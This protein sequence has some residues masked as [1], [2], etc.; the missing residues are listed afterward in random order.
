MNLGKRINPRSQKVTIRHWLTLPVCTWLGLVFSASNAFAESRGHYSIGYQYISVDGFEATFGK[1]DIGTTDTHTLTFDVEYELTRRLTVS[2]GL[3]LVRKR[4][5]GPIPHRVDVLEPAQDAKFIDDGKYRTNFQDLH[6]GLR[7]KW[8]EGRPWSVEPFVGYSFPTNDYSFFGHAAVGQNLWHVELG[9]TITYVPHFYD[10]YVSVTPSW[11]FVEKTLGHSVHHY[12]VN[13]T[14][15]YRFTDRFSGRIFS[16]V[17]NGKGLDN[18]DFPQ[19]QIDEEWFYHDK[20]IA[21]NYINAGVGIDWNYYKDQSLSFSA[22]RMVY[23]DIV[24]IMDYSFSL[25]LSK[26]F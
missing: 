16:L 21:H 10:Y 14:L 25:T 1:L 8:I 11:V 4:F 15:G 3:P 2:A 6:L 24:H 5:R 12:R 26:S 7:Y 22:M 19:P 17:K 23:A 18:T 20:T 13:A 9:A